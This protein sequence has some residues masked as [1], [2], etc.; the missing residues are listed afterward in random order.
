MRKGKDYLTN[1]ERVE[2]IEQ[3]RFIELDDRSLSDIN[4]SNWAQR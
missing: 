3:G 2:R 4:R 1:P